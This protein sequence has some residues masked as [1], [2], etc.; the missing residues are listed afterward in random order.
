MH[1]LDKI[2]AHKQEEVDALKNRVPEK[3]LKA[4]HKSM[5][6]PQPMKQSL[7][8]SGRNGIIAEFKRRSPSAGIINNRVQ[9]T[10]VAAAYMEARCAGISILTDY[11]FFGGSTQDLKAVR[12]IADVPLLRK[13]FIIDPYQIT[14]SRA[15]GASTILLIASVLSSRQL[16]DFT[17][18]A[19]EY[20]MEALVE[21]HDEAEIRKIPQNA[22]LVGINNRN[23]KNFEVNLSHAVHLKKQIPGKFPLVAESGIHTA[24]DIA[25][26]K[27]Q[28]FS[29][30]LIGTALMKQADPGKALK[31]LDREL[32]ELT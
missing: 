17:E 18:K 22:D 10:E 15:M 11:H 16:A 1:I 21:I 8:N 14:E 9:V 20:G 31:L 26:L 7:A 23:L 2:V 32:Q 19:H 28:G 30:F 6:P 5:M 25:Y 13:D 27:E 24:R 4:L 29:G 3:H 12:A